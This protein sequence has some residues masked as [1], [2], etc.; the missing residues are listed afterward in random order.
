MNDKVDLLLKNAYELCHDRM[1]NNL[2]LSVD[3]IFEESF[4]VIAIPALYDNDLDEELKYRSNV[5]S[6]IDSIDTKKL[7]NDIQ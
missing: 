7:K 5:N 2:S 1:R 4:L 6:M 3:N